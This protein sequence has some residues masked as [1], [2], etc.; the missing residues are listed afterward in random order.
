MK[1]TNI[2]IGVLLFLLIAVSSAS[3]YELGQT[4]DATSNAASIGKVDVTAVYS[5]NT[6]TFTAKDLNGGSADIKQVGFMIDPSKVSTITDSAGITWYPNPD[7][8]KNAKNNVLT[9]GQMDGLGT[10]STTAVDVDESASTKAS[11]V[12]VTLK[13]GNNVAD[14]ITK[15]DHVPG[16]ETCAHVAWTGG[17]AG[18]GGS[19]FVSGNIPEFPTVA[20]PVA[21]ILGLLFISGRKRKE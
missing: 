11:V 19:A 8:S 7:T 1:A 9:A 4:T 10:Y 15:N 6:I 18:V 16:F 12:T 17:T 5:G 21:A 14:L 3:A 13:S 20:A 2:I